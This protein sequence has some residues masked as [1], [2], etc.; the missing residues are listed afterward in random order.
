MLAACFAVPYFDIYNNGN[1][2]YFQAA[3]NYNTSS[4]SSALSYTYVAY[5]NNP[6]SYVDDY[7]AYWYFMRPSLWS[8]DEW[9]CRY[10]LQEVTQLTRAGYIA[11]DAAGLY[12]A[13]VD[14]STSRGDP[15]YRKILWWSSQASCS[16]WSDSCC[17]DVGL[18]PGNKA[19]SCGSMSWPA[20]P[21]VACF[22]QPT[23]QHCAWL[24]PK[25][26]DC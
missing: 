2:G 5:N 12:E 7:S 15:N 16:T 20:A 25:F 8:S 14:Y 10:A 4:N 3:Y 9:T 11:N 17:S 6:G 1:E 26:V 13:C 22:R 19:V 21:S 24:C 18:K 23:W